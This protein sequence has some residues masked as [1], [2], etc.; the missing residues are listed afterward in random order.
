[1]LAYTE[2]QATAMTTIAPQGLGKASQKAFEEEWL[3]PE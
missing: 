3:F 1:M 2:T